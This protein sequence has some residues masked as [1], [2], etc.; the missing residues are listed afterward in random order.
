MGEQLFTCLLERWMWLKGKMC[1]LLA[2]K[3]ASQNFWNYV[4]SGFR[5][6]VCSSR[7]EYYLHGAV[8]LMWRRQ[9]CGVLAFTDLKGGP[10]TSRKRMVPSHGGSGIVVGWTCTREPRN[11]EQQ[12]VGHLPAESCNKLMT[13]VLPRGGYLQRRDSSVPS[14]GHPECCTWI[15]RPC[16]DSPITPFC[17]SILGFGIGIVITYLSHYCILEILH[18]Y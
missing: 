7:P 2:G 16:S 3:V 17:F 11:V 13:Y 8:L 1:C 14:R 10:E 4:L 9:E 5:C 15:F 12:G 6:S 18:C